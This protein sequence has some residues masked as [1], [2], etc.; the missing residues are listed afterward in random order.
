MLSASIAISLLNIIVEPAWL[1]KSQALWIKACAK[2]TRHFSTRLDQCKGEFEC[3]LRGGSSDD[4]L[5]TTRA[6]K[7][8]SLS[9]NGIVRRK[10]V[11]Y[12]LDWIFLS[13]CSL[14]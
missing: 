10:V 5:V 6:W 13:L 9:C 12:F 1:T 14:S 2:D 3:C 7:L 4:F 11:K 8:C